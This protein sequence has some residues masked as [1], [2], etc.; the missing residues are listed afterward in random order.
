MALAEAQLGRVAEE[1]FR[2]PPQVRHRIFTAPR[3]IA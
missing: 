3:L 2:A 1:F